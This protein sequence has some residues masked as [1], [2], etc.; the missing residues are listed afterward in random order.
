MFSP[1]YVQGTEDTTG[2]GV[3]MAISEPLGSGLF[4]GT[5]AFAAVILG[6]RANKV[7]P[8]RCVCGGGVGI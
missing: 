1:A 2:E 6:A 4:V 8:H 3:S 5:V 7:G